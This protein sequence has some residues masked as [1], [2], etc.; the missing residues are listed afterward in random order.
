MLRMKNNRDVTTK[1][2][3]RK[4]PRENS[5]YIASGPNGKQYFFI[6]HSSRIRQYFPSFSVG[7]LW[8]VISCQTEKRSEV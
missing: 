2:G 7:L 5:A 3:C 6:L 1:N 8:L 4:H